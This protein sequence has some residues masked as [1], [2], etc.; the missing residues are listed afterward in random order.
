MRDDALKVVQQQHTR[1]ANA[2]IKHISAQDN[3][4]KLQEAAEREEEGQHGSPQ[5]R[6]DGR[7]ITLALPQN[8]ILASFQNALLQ[9]QNTEEKQT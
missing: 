2:A 5:S 6:T 4:S 9:I 3:F 1:A 7:A 8:E